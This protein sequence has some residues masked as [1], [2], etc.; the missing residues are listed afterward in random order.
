[1]ESTFQPLDAAEVPAITKV[2][3]HSVCVLFECIEMFTRFTLSS[4][5]VKAHELAKVITNPGFVPPFGDH[6]IGRISG[7]LVAIVVHYQTDR[8]SDLVSLGEILLI[9]LLSGSRVRL[10]LEKIFPLAL[11]VGLPPFRIAQLGLE[12]IR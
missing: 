4:S 10:N 6:L 9:V 8:V 1:S 5:L 3:A 2:D 12:F 7:L 11:A